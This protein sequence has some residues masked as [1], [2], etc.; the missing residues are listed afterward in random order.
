[1]LSDKLMSELHQLSHAEKLR[2]VQLLVNELASEAGHDTLT[3]GT[4]YEIWS[5]YDAFEAA[6][7]LQEMLDQYKRDHDQP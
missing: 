1:M 7:Q 5:P 3:P 6:N 2:V 4:S